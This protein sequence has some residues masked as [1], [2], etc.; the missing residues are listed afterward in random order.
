[1]GAPH[2]IFVVARIQPKPRAGGDDQP[3]KDEMDRTIST[4][5]EFRVLFAIHHQSLEGIAVLASC[6]RILDAVRNNSHAIA[7]EL[8]T[9]DPISWEEYC[10]AY[11]YDED[12]TDDYGEY[13][14]EVHSEGKE[15]LP[16][17]LLCR[18]V[19]DATLFEPESSYLQY[20]NRILAPWRHYSYAEN[21]EGYTI[22]D[23]TDPANPAHCFMWCLTE[24][25]VTQ[26]AAE[27]VNG[28]YRDAIAAGCGDLMEKLGKLPRIASSEILEIWPSEDTRIDETVIALQQPSL[29]NP[30]APKSPSDSG[31]RSLKSLSW[32]LIFSSCLNG[33]S[34]GSLLDICCEIPHLEWEEVIPC[35]RSLLE[36]EA[37][38]TKVPS[39][40][41]EI[42]SKAYS[43]ID[44]GTTHVL[45]FSV[46][47]FNRLTGPQLATVIQHFFLPGSVWDGA[48]A[49]YTIE[50]LNLS[51]NPHLTTPCVEQILN[52]I[53]KYITIKKLILIDCPLVDVSTLRL[54]PRTVSTAGCTGPDILDL[55][56]PSLAMRTFQ[57]SWPKIKCE[58]F[59]IAPSR[60]SVFTLVHLI[61]ET[62][63]VEFP[64]VEQAQCY[65]THPRMAVKGL[66][67]YLGYLTYMIDFESMPLSSTAARCF[68]GCYIEAP[69]RNHERFVNFGCGDP[70]G[71]LY[72]KK[73]ETNRK[74]VEETLE[75][76][77]E[78][79][80]YALF[81]GSHPW[82][83]RW[84]RPDSG[85]FFHYGFVRLE[86]DGK[87][88][89]LSIK[90]ILATCL[91]P[92]PE[93]NIYSPDDM[94][95]P[96]VKQVC[97]GHLK[98][99]NLFHGPLDVPIRLFTEEEIRNAEFESM[100]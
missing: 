7:T 22:V 96:R 67:N 85:L 50:I 80:A 25:D 94:E 81:V 12:D 16:C 8:R 38:D 53:P 78:T 62:Y 59:P 2:Q 86:D 89:I 95:D 83:A 73:V 10:S 20:R 52:K 45:D 99:K 64:M 5:P 66:I 65:F 40:M 29:G 37:S 87:L 23:V 14:T 97:E 28:Q 32:D 42:L 4:R 26:S 35:A 76:S 39:S 19:W 11:D 43:N 90:D 77:R 17:P 13:D 84:H 51:F 48:A 6:S 88:S 31:P 3:Q 71:A 55:Q 92:G 100:A 79:G 74:L 70:D 47:P 63:D 9:L 1:M 24:G 98:V 60:G 27:Y 44:S 33:D 91:K 18:T 30:Q 49:S 46:S 34:P 21:Q 36:K 54:A 56:M 68:D 58:N 93:G 75:K 72:A 69:P 61:P 15:L 57:N 41:V 82:E